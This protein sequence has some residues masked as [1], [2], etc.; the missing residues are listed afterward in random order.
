[1]NPAPKLLLGQVW[2]T[3]TILISIKT[4]KISNKRQKRS[5]LLPQGLL[6]VRQ[7]KVSKRFGHVRSVIV[8]ALGQHKVPMV[9]QVAVLI[10]NCSIFLK[11]CPERAPRQRR[12]RSGQVFKNGPWV[13]ARQWKLTNRRNPTHV[14]KCKPKH[15]KVAT[16]PIQVYVLQFGLWENRETWFPCE[17]NSRNETTRCVNFSFP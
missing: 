7:D 15:A 11:T 4:G 6:S 10:L 5:Q 1:M 8:T 12:G 9:I 14:T 13:V 17:A 16:V 2:T 3:L